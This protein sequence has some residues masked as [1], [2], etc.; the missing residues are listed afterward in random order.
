MFQRQ[1]SLQKRLAIFCLYI[2]C[3]L[4]HA[5]VCMDQWNCLGICLYVSSYF[6]LFM[7][8]TL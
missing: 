7:H 2:S 4:L 6:V 8:L 1:V 5:D 3:Q